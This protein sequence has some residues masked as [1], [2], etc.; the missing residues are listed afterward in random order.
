LHSPD[1]ENTGGTFCGGLEVAA[2]SDPD[3]GGTGGLGGGPA[4]AVAVAASGAGDVNDASNDSNDDITGR[5]AARDVTD[6]AACSLAG[7]YGTDDDSSGGGGHTAHHGR[8]SAEERLARCDE[9]AREL[10][11]QAALD[12]LRRQSARGAS[13]AARA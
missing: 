13:A 10:K 6:G 7:H 11:D 3:D 1:S 12:A 9:D 5:N 4:A 2:S 8:M